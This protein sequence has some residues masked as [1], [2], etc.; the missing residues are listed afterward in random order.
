M[1]TQPHSKKRISY[2]YD[3]DIGN[4][5]NGEGYPIKPHMAHN[6]VL[7]YGLFKTGRFIGLTRP[8]RT[9]CQNNVSQYIKQ[10]KRFHVGEDCP[11]FDGMYEFCQLFAG[12][13]VAGAVKLNKQAA[14]I[15]DF[16]TTD[17]VMTVSFNKYRNYFP[18]TGDLTGIDVVN[19]KYY[20]VNIPLKVVMTKFM[21]MCKPSAIV[22]QC[23]GK[24]VEMMKIWNLPIFLLGGGGHTTKNVARCW[25]YETAVVLGEELAN[26]FPYNDYF[27]LYGQDFQLHISHSNMTNKNTPKYFDKINML[28]FENIR[29]LPHAPGVQ[30]Q[31]I[32]ADDINNESD[33]DEEGN[34][35]QR[36]SIRDSDKRILCIEEFLDS[37]DEVAK[38]AGCRNLSLMTKELLDLCEN[39]TADDS[40]PNPNE[41]CGRKAKTN[42]RKC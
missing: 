27:K 42:N 12:G 7:T 32:P 11:V 26:Q 17:R 9:R 18:G 36:I 22:M 16:Y 4:Y 30:M 8:H 2:Y 34:P 3:E 21:Q 28:M 35:D 19:G 40:I 23:Y 15:E 24:Y 31:A 20:S 29:M 38:G 39:A 10:M 33:D 41:S 5:Y 1:A 37:E 6:L 25:T 13:Y 14:D